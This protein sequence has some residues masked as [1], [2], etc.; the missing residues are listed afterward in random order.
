MTP[1]KFT[2]GQTVEFRPGAGDLPGS[3]GAYT[4]LRALPGDDLD[5]TYRARGAGDGQE[6]V[7][8]E[9]QLT[10]AARPTFG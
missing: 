8:R 10:P 2:V 7:L 1:H 4:I 3:R 9:K 6:R 5:R